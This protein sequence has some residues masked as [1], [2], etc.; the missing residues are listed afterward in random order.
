M[1][2]RPSPEVNALGQ[3]EDV[4]ELELTDAR[5]ADVEGTPVR[6]ALPRRGRRTVGAWCFL[7]HMGP[8]EAT[9]ERQMRIGPHPHTGLHTV[10]WLLSGEVVHTDSLGSEQPIRPGQLNLMTAGRG[11]SHAEEGDGSYRGQVQGLQLWV[12]Q[13]DSTRHGEPAFE[14]HA[15]LPMIELTNG[16]GTMLVGSVGAVAAAT[17]Q[18]TPLIGV[19]LDLRSGVG[20]LALHAD[21]EHALYV[22]QGALRIE[23]TV[24]PTGSMTYLGLG[25]DSVSWEASEPTRAMLLGGQPL[26]EDVFVWWNFVLRSQDEVTEA[27]SAWHDSDDRFG[28]VA[29]ALA[30]IDAPVPPW[31]HQ[32]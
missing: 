15:E 32:T 25:R 5:L 16:I 20:E 28:T 2:A 29:S 27:Y 4:A 13:P 9:A 19:D 6:R 1:K 8:M 12:A 30:R 10:T 21:H 14:H 26:G 7:D 23:G 11:V 31:L 24:I 22:L 17:R 18:D 3:D